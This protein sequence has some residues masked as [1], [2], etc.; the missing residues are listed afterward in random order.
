MQSIKTAPV[1]TNLGNFLIKGKFDCG[2][3]AL[4]YN[5][6]RVESRFS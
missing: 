5:K 6:P 1:E 2:K 4:P 3:A